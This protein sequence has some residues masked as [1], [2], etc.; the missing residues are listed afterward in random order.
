MSQSNR[1]ILNFLN[2]TELFAS[3]P[4]LTEKAIQIFDFI[5]FLLDND[6]NLT[7]T[8]NLNIGAKNLLHSRIEEI[9]GRKS[10]DDVFTE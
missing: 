5:Q 2:E 9:F 3:N 10:L 8:G 6:Q 7:K 1:I 4:D